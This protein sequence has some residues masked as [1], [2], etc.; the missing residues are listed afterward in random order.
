MDKERGGAH[1][2]TGDVEC[3]DAIKAA[4]GEHFEGYLAGNIIKYVWR[5]R[6]KE[7]MRDLLKAQ[8]Y[9]D[10][11]METVEQGGQHD[12]CAL[13]VSP[14]GEDPPAKGRRGRGRV[15][16]VRSQRH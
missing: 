3:I 7:G 1:Y 16:K 11:L 13:R 8:H 5:Y 6:L 14:C 9:L 2:K 10:W 12:V 4:T 15:S